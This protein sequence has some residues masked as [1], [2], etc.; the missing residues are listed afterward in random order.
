MCDIPFNTCTIFTSAFVA[1]IS[2]SK[3]LTAVVITP[4]IKRG[5]TVVLADSGKVLQWKSRKIEKRK[6]KRKRYRKKNTNMYQ[7]SNEWIEQKNVRQNE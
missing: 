2:P 7:K 4:N 1:P 6:R 5:V 3:D